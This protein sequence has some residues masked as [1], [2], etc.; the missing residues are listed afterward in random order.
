MPYLILVDKSYRHPA[1]RFNQEFVLAKAIHGPWIIGCEFGAGG[2]CKFI[3]GAELLAVVRQ[4]IGVAVHHDA[5]IIQ[6][7]IV[8]VIGVL[9]S[10]RWA[11][12]L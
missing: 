2:D 1:A 7:H 9:L 3:I 6:G 10:L 8:L 11:G 5:A 4:H 12:L